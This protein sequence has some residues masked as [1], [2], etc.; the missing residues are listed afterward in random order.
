M[1]EILKKISF[2]I[3]AK[4]LID[5]AKESISMAI[6]G[7]F[8][9]AYYWFVTRNYVSIFGNGTRSADRNNSNLTLQLREDG[10]MEL[11]KLSDKTVSDL[12][13]Y[14]LESQQEQFA[15]LKSFFD[16]KRAQNFVRTEVVDIV[17]NEKLCKSMLSELKIMPIVTEFLGLSES[18]LLISAKV[19]AL[20]LI[21]GE[22]KTRNNYD[23][24]LEF[25]RDIDSLRFVKA[26]VYLVDID[27]GFGE[28]E[29]CIRSHKSLPLNLRT[30]QRHK[31]SRLKENLP[32]FELKSIFGKAGYSWIEDTTTFHRGTVPTAGNRLMLSLSFNDKKSGAHL[33]DEYYHSMQ[34]TK[35]E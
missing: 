29:V 24:A 18:E 25:H 15:N 9:K 5:T 19:D 4:Q 22:R 30:I 32:H 20:I 28:H 10:F 12:V 14:F 21:D 27:K 23:D 16:K 31:Y 7:D 26:F 2:L 11:D 3:V 33:Y 35:P 8:L 6:R 13:D 34:P 17:P 1:K